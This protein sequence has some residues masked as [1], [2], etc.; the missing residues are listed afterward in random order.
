ML[1]QIIEAICFRL[2]NG[3]LGSSP[4]FYISRLEIKPGDFL[5]I[6]F[7]KGLTQQQ[8]SRLRADMNGILPKDVKVMIFEGEVDF[9][10]L[11][12]DQKLKLVEAA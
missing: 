12:P 1:K 6:R 11:S 4:Q 9:S 8:A 10:V 5:V 7:R 3:P 2:I